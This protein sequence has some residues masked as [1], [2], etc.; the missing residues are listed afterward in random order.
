MRR[1]NVDIVYAKHIEI[2]V[3]LSWVIYIETNNVVTVLNTYKHRLNIKRVM[4][5][6]WTNE[7]IFM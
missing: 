3:H 5:K 2:N 7:Q 6:L 1:M 4:N